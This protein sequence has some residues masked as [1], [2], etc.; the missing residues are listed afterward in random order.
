MIVNTSNKADSQSTDAAMAR[1]EV[2]TQEITLARSTAQIDKGLEHLRLQVAEASARTVAARERATRP[3]TK[4]C[5]RGD[6]GIDRWLSHA[7]N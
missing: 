3:V 4:G 7:W 1:A 2:V 6:R 5:L